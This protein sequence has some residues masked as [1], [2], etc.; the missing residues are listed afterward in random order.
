M[1]LY[2]TML[3]SLAGGA[4]LSDVIAPPYD[5]ISSEERAVL[6]ARHPN[7]VVRLELPEGDGDA[8]YAAAAELLD[9]WRRTG[10]LGPARL[11]VRNRQ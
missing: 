9:A 11:L 3:L 8:K 2:R 5:V 6:V 10:V 1:T 7:N 4:V